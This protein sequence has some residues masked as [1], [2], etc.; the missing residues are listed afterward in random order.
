MKHW[1][2]A[3]LLLAACG[4]DDT[5]EFPTTSCA[6]VTGT[7]QELAAGDPAALVT[8]AN[9]IEANTTLVLGTGTFTM[10]GALTIRTDGAHIIG[11]GMDETI[12][13]FGQSTAQS[14]GVDAQSDDFLLQGVTVVDAP[15]DA[16]RVEAS[17]GVVLRDVKTTWTTPGDMTNGGYGLYPVKSENV[18]VE[19]CVAEHASDAGLYVGQ[20]Q[21]V[22]VRNNLVQNNVA[23]LE[24][25]NTQFADV[26][27]NTAT[28]NT[29]GIVVFDL[30]GNP[31]VGR[32]VRLRDNMIIENNYQNFAPGGTV[33]VIPAGTGTFAMASRR[34][35]ITGNT[36]QGNKTVD[37]A[38]ISGLV[39]EENEVMWELAT[40]DLQGE[41]DDLGLAVGATP[42]TITNFRQENVLVANNT[43]S[44]SGADPDTGDPF[45]FGLLLGA[46]YSGIG[47]IDSVLYDTIGEPMFSSTDQ[48]MNTNTNRICV[49]ANTGGT[50]ASMNLAVQMPTSI[51]PF[52][53]PAAPFA[54][55]DCTALAN[56]PVAEVILP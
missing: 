26:Y 52:F 41:W 54:P 23:G 8:A 42:N 14:N 35:E 4:G 22:I 49:G 28:N 13:D 27:N 7:C 17:I 10:T 46:A 29:A 51:I 45:M 47:P 24:I 38:L 36:Y 50:F 31:I 53:R 40:A 20:S 43:H 33:A 15:K 30:P 5:N 9:S 2:L 39:V 21:R 6:D 56:G 44:G 11:Q 25:E 55:F 12:I 37:I 32:D 19:D 16:V 34:V 3:C 1:G 18:L 48:L